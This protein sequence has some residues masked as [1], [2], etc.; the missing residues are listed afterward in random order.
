MNEKLQQAMIAARNGQATEAQ[1]L[2]TEVLKEDPGE[3]QAWFLLSNLVESKQKKVAY[4]SKT[5]AL[6]P[7]HDM[8]KQMLARLQEETTEAEAATDVETI[9]EAETAEALEIQDAAETVA[10]DDA[11][12]MLAI[13]ESDLSPEPEPAPEPPTAA[14]ELDD[15]ITPET[16][17][18]LTDNG[19]TDVGLTDVGLTDVGLTDVGLTDVD[20][21]DVG[22]PDWLAE[23]ELSWEQASPDL[24]DTEPDAVIPEAPDWL[25]DG[26]DEARADEPPIPEPEITIVEPA[27]PKPA[28]TKSIEPAISPDDVRQKQQAALTRILYALIAVAAVILA[29]MLYLIWTTF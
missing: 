29:I 23:E 20:L 6:D 12:E 1:L 9:A 22:L 28:E 21:T 24:T 17:N 26:D 18:G 16:D 15:D 2:L 14:L 4:L 7:Q 25:S 19:L 3:T 27:E 5:L 8:A 13:F 11:A 10:T